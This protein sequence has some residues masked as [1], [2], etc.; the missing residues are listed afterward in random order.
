MEKLTMEVRPTTAGQREAGAA[1]RKAYME[2]AR[3][4]RNIEPRQR[5][6]AIIVNGVMCYE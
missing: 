2:K 1:W 3:K 5:T 4:A 6:K